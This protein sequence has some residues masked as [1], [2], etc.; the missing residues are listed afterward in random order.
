MQIMTVLENLVDFLWGQMLDSQ[1]NRGK[2][3]ENN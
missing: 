3:Y 1:N 2:N